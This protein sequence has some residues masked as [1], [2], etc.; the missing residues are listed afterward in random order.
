MSFI[1]VIAAATGLGLMDSPSQAGSTLLTN[2]RIV[3]SPGKVIGNGYLLIENGRIAK[4]G[5]GPMARSGNAKPVDLKGMTVYAAFIHPGFGTSVTGVSSSGGGA[6]FGRPQT[7]LSAAEEATAQKKRDEDPFNREGNFLLGKSVAGAEKLEVE[8]LESL[9]KVGYGLVNVE[10]NGGMIEARSAISATGSKSLQSPIDS[11]LVNIAVGGRGGGSYPSS[12]MG[13]IYVIRQA[14]VDAQGYSG[15]DAGLNRLNRATAGLDRAFFDDLT[16]VSFFQAQRIVKE[17]NLRPVYGFRSDAGRV[18]DLLKSS[19]AEVIL[20]GRVPTAPKLTD[21]FSR[22]SLKS[23]RDYF[24]EVQAGAE[25][26]KSG[27]NFAYSPSSTITPM[28]GIRT[29]VQGGLSRNAALAAMTTEPAKILGVS[30]DYGTLEAGKKAS[31]VVVQG[32]IFDKS[33]QVMATYIDGKAVAFEMPK[34]KDTAELKADEPIKVVAPN[35]AMF[36]APAE[37]VAAFRIYKNATVWTEGPRGVV[38]NCDVVIKDGKIVAVGQKLANPA[39]AEV[40]DATGK[41][42]SPGIWDCH[43]HTAITGSVNEFTNMVTAECR[44]RDCMDHTDASIYQQLSGGTVGANQLHGSANAIGGQ[45]NTVKWRWGLRPDE[46]PVVGAPEGVKFALGQNPISEDDGSFRGTAVG[47]TLLT[48]R[49]RTRM[50][51]EEAIRK[52]FDLGLEYN[53]SWDDF[54]S[55]KTTIAPRRDL[56]LEA[57]G[58]IVSGK[59]WI[60]SHGYRADELLMLIRV[61]K[62]YGAKLATLQHV[63]EGYKI[64]DEMAQAGVGGSTFADWW[65]FKLE[66]YDAVPYNLALMSD[67]GV[68]TSVNSDSNN[69]ARRLNQEA[70]KAMR[71]GGVDAQTALSFVTTGPTKQLGIDRFTGSLEAGKDADLV[72]WTAEPMSIYSIALETYVDGVKRFDRANDAEQRKA[73]EI[74]IKAAKAVLDAGGSAS[75]FTTGGGGPVADAKADE[76]TPTTAAFGLADITGQPGTAK[77]PRHAVLLQGGTVHP[78]TGAPFV[79]DVMIGA[80][81]KIEAVGQ[82]LSPKGVEVVD[83]SG[84]HVY[85]GLI[86]PATGLG[87][88]E[89]G[90]VPASDDSSERGDF[91]ADYRVERAINPEWDTLGVARQQG[92]LTAIVKP[93]GGGIPGQAALINTEGYTWED[94]T[95]QGGVAL[96]YSVGRGGGRFGDGNEELSNLC[97]CEDGIAEHNHILDLLDEELRAGQGRGQGQQT[98]APGMDVLT[99]RLKEAK[100]YSEKRAAATAEKPVPRNQSLEAMLLVADGKLPIMIS[101]T[102]AD[103][104]KSAVAWAE[105]NKVKILLYGC[106]GAGEIADWLAAKKVPVILSAIYGMPR[107]DQPVDYYYTMPGLLAKAG[108]KFAITLNDD[109]DARQMRDQ[110]GWAAAYGMNAED[111]VRS[112]TLWTAQ[113]LGIDNR[114][115]AIQP[116]LDGTVILTDGEIIETRSQVLRAWIQGREVPLTNRQTR[117][118]DKYR[119]RPRPGQG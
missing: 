56:Q 64:A 66:A 39:G 67:R 87:L 4:V 98:P 11:S 71:Y 51:V 1:A 43:S 27:V 14:L 115:G 20:Q 111:A 80:N 119:A 38:Q 21:D 53:K 46:Y 84:K 12:T 90:Q 5:E 47:G 108:V 7:T 34:A 42:I 8:A 106:S 30:G 93:S 85:P 63:L 74:E 37:M 22:V 49:P 97:R 26:E 78:M 18:K 99:N 23:V 81:G 40:I 25:L 96:M 103:D 65:G 24:N 116:G 109:H 60:H 9:S 69:H 13:I 33:S 29:Y 50:G 86:D 68:V 94:M 3:V 112:M 102:S 91:H 19:G 89:I 57:L 28:E 59:R 32:D 76:L 45:S 79:G 113:I 31:I 36:P 107:A 17:F 54:R 10:A 44:I 48:F 77:Y 105:E 83:A 118:N 75:P 88:N 6:S 92:I 114:V 110:A 35:Y 95:I 70:A 55:G 52:A 117:L 2:C 104:I 15:A 101:A 100:E 61:A 72:V 82:N 62:Q 58:E 41:H 73:R 16:E